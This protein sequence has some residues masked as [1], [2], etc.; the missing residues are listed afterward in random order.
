M[1]V[2]SQFAALLDTHQ[3]SDLAPSPRGGRFWATLG[4]T[5][6]AC[7][8]GAALPIFAAGAVRAETCTFLQPIGGNGATPIVSKSVGRGKLIGQ[9]N[10]WTDFIVDRPYARYKYFFTANSSDP[11]AQY[12]VE[13]YMKFSDGSNLQL[14]NVMMSP[15]IGTGREFGPYPQV[16]GKQ[17]SQISFKVGASNDPGALGFSYRVSVQ[18]CN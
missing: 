5:A 3:D 4:C 2:F 13:G 7:L 9:T 17:A 8:G 11:K 6:A 18:G 14:F 15:P 10:W 16:P 12:P 1:S